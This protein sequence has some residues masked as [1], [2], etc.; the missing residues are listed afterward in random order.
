MLTDRFNEA[1]AYAE[2]AHRSQ[3]R[4]GSEIPV[5]GQFENTY[6]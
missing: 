4:K 1:L 5:V 6:A 2:Y 3:K